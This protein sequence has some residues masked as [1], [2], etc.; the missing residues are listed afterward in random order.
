MNT[1]VINVELNGTHETYTT[2]LHDDATIMTPADVIFMQWRAQ[3]FLTATLGYDDA[4]IDYT[5]PYKS[6]C[7]VYELWRDCMLVGHAM[8]RVWIWKRAIDILIT[9]D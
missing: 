9:E 2:L 8:V 3:Q 7:R 1:I 6:L 5:S 4:T